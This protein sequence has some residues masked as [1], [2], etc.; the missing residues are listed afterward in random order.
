M[1]SG[2]QSDD[3]FQFK[4]RKAKVTST[5]EFVSRLCIS[6]NESWRTRVL[7]QGKS[8]GSSLVI[9]ADDRLKGPKCT[10]CQQKDQS[11]YEELFQLVSEK[12]RTGAC[13]R[14]KQST[15]LVVVHCS[16]QL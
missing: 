15:A 4:F 8:F 3:N 1:L 6:F 14:Q 13:A 16:I 7:L 2:A 9:N 10:H 5:G 11:D 12:C